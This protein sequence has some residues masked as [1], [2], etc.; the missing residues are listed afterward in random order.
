MTMTPRVSKIV[1][2][3]HITFSVGW[4]GAVAVFLALAITGLTTLNIQ[5]AR[6]T[7]WAMELSTWFVIIPFCLASLLSG[8]VQALGTPWGL[9]KHYWILVKLLLTI[10]MTIL[11]L[12]HLKPISF[13]A[14]VAADPLFENAKSSGL[15]IDLIA[16]TGA[17]I[18]VLLATTTI[19]IYKPWGKTP[20]GQPS[21][22]KQVAKR[23]LSFYLFTGL[24]ILIVIFV[25]T[26][27]FG[28]GMSH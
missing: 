3:S 13:L 27:L 7:Y 8:I 25:L 6:S 9:I 22:P 12:L 1:L 5:L 17:A 19:S 20:F 10:G 11:L 23:S 24:I 26:H 16:K 2:T 14:G 4:F 21:N 15:L 18:L 28:G